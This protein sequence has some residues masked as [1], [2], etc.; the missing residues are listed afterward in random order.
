LLGAR[1]W[2]RVPPRAFSFMVSRGNTACNSTGGRVVG[3]RAVVRLT[4]L[5]ATSAQIRPNPRFRATCYPLGNSRLFP[6]L[7]A[8]SAI[9][10]SGLEIA[11]SIQLSY[12]GRSSVGEVRLAVTS[13]FYRRATAQETRPF[14]RRSGVGKGPTVDAIAKRMPTMPKTARCLRAKSILDVAFAARDDNGHPASP[15]SGEFICA[16]ASCLHYR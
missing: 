15:F 6:R 14:K 11:C 13:P 12:G 5:G 1:L 9:A 8:I 10:Q 7:L 16:A 3:K 2:V 4:T